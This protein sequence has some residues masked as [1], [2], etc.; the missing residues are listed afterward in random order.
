MTD[1]DEGG[2][3]GG[4]GWTW[5]GSREEDGQKERRPAMRLSRWVW[6][7]GEQRRGEVD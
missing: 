2:E 6:R 4:G 1:A 7:G 3:T 5:P